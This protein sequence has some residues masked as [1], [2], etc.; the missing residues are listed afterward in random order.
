MTID[1]ES[2][3]F[4]A[5]SRDS[6]RANIFPVDVTSILYDN[7]QSR[8][9]QK[10]SGWH[11]FVWLLSWLQCVNMSTGGRCRLTADQKVWNEKFC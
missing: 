10:D 11:V 8:S 3:V 6:A 4:V 9:S 2:V 1:P 5:G 7:K